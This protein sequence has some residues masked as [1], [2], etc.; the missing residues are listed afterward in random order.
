MNNNLVF[1]I[2]DGDRTRVAY[3]SDQIKRKFIYADHAPKRRLQKLVKDAN[4]KK[5]PAARQR[6][7]SRSLGYKSGE[8][9]DAMLARLM[10]EKISALGQAT[11]K[12]H[13][14]RIESGM[15][16]GPRRANDSTP[17][18]LVW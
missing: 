9:S 5:S 1:R 18:T 16:R 8:Y 3:W 2:Y 14:R 12:E 15:K 11:R 10:R 4:A 17:D 7:M 13:R 6:F